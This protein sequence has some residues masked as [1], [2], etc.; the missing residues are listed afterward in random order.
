MGC[1]IH[2][3][4]IVFCAQGEETRRDIFAASPIT[5]QWRIIGTEGIALV[6]LIDGTQGEIIAESPIAL[7]SRYKRIP[8][9]PF[10]MY[11]HSCPQR[12]SDRLKEET[13]KTRRNSETAIRGRG[14][15]RHQCISH[16]SDGAHPLR[17]SDSGRT[18]LY[19]ADVPS[20]CT[21]RGLA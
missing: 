7:Q 21:G 1:I 12:Q 4:R 13:D 16:G 15:I 20:P 2:K 17:Q 9:E 10:P 8:N 14:V 18:E 11:G 19:F 3:E 5:L 6:A